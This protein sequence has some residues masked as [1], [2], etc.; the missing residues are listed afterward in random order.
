[1]LHLGGKVQ[2][3][4]AVVVRS[5]RG[6]RSGGCSG[7]DSR[8]RIQERCGN[9]LFRGGTD[10]KITAGDSVV[11][12][13]ILRVGNDG[14]NVI[15]LAEAIGC[16]ADGEHFVV[17][18]DID[19]LRALVGSIEQTEGHLPGGACEFASP[20]R[21]DNAAR[22]DARSHVAIAACPGN[23]EQSHA[24]HEERPLF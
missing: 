6:C 10:R 22:M 1:M 3:S 24:F 8:L 2:L 13:G 5:L 20:R 17:I 12:P 7:G 11:A 4:R 18:P 16:A 14:A 9:L 15:R 19:I 23:V 21:I